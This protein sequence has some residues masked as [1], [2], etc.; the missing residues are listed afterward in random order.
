MKKITNTNKKQLQDSHQGI[1]K[2]K[3]K[4]YTIFEVSKGQGWI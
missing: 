4:V 1:Y 3:L 2:N